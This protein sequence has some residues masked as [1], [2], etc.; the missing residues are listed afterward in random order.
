MG[1]PG[2]QPLTLAAVEAALNS[3]FHGTI[4]HVG[5]GDMQNISVGDGL[6]GLTEIDSL[7]NAPYYGLGFVW[8]SNAARFTEDCFLEHWV[9]APD[10]GCAAAFGCTDAV[11][12]NAAFRFT[13]ELFV[14]ITA[15]KGVLLGAAMEGARSVFLGNTFWNTSDRW[16]TLTLALL[17]DP[18]MPYRGDSGVPT[19][20]TSSG[21]SGGRHPDILQLSQNSPNPFN[22][23]TVIQCALPHDSW[24]ELE[25]FDLAGRKVATIHEGFEEAGYK[26]IQ[27]NAGYLSSGT[28]I[29]RLRAG[30]VEET[31]KLVIIK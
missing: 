23:G 11:F 8:T 6:L 2:S 21:E 30:G 10:G 17:G 1:Y 25:L 27:W 13:R 15:D 20:T 31:K 9:R 4:L 16:T 24:V 5:H 18:A 29:Y 19:S 26:T 7:T 28:Y 14:E 12:P 3:G 22:P